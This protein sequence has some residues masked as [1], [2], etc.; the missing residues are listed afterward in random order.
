MLQLI[1]NELFPVGEAHPHRQG[2][3]RFLLERAQQLFGKWPVHI[4]F[5][6]LASTQCNQEIR[7]TGI[8]VYAS[9]CS[10]SDQDPHT[11]EKLILIWH[12]ES[13]EIS[14]PQSVPAMLNG[15]AW[16]ELAAKV[17]C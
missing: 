14:F 16:I 9:C 3:T 17:D 2:F 10:F 1:S 13:M 4:V 8:R 11:I 6:E 12:Q 15:I 5:P 7:F